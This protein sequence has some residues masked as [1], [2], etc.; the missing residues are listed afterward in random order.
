MDDASVESIT[1]HGTTSS[2]TPPALHDSTTTTEDVINLVDDL[3]DDD[4]N[5]QELSCT[6]DMSL[7]EG[8]DDTLYWLS[9]DQ[10]CDQR[11]P[12]NASFL[13][14]KPSDWKDYE[15]TT[16]QISFDKAR[17]ELWQQ[18]QAEVQT[19]KQNFYSNPTI[20]EFLKGKPD[21]NENCQAALY[22]LLLGA[23]SKLGIAIREAT[24]MD[25]LSYLKFL[26]TFILSCQLNSTIINLHENSDIRMD[27]IS[28]TEEY[29]KVWRQI[30]KAGEIQHNLTREDPLWVKVEGIFNNIAKLLFMSN[31]P[32]F[33]YV[34]A[35]DDDKV[36]FEYE[37]FSNTNGLKRCRHVKANAKGF[38]L[39]VAGFGASQVPVQVAWMREGDTEETCYRRMVGNMYGIQC[40]PNN[41]P[42]INNSNFY[43]DL[44]YWNVSLLFNFFLLTGAGIGGTLKRA[45][46]L[47]YTY[48]EKETRRTTGGANAGE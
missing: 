25:E 7:Q 27:F 26:H 36:H 30:L 20:Q 35:L 9:I 42:T 24:Q 45:D 28:T 8:N 10:L 43:S 21:T 1:I 6:F 37:K 11:T 4:D 19:F 38:V 23:N 18:L 34:I 46:W 12:E 44:G 17:S 40:G 3:S 2:S 39:H 29:N 22:N 47:P 33:H 14:P 32:N 31:D 48:N 41:R 5:D 15:D 13:V 16:A